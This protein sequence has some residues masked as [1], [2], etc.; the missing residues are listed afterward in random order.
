MK[1]K[2]TISPLVT[3]LNAAQVADYILKNEKSLMHT[4]SLN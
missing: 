1:K 4:L 2:I 3:L